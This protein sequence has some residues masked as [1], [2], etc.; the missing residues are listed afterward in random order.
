M[1]PINNF[2]DKVYVTTIEPHALRRES[3]NS[4]LKNITFEYFDEIDIT[5][6]EYRAY[7]YVGDY[8]DDFF[9]NLNLDKT[10]ARVWS[11]GQLGCFA[12]CIQLIKTAIKNDYGSVLAIEDDVVFSKKAFSV[13]EHAL[14]Q[15][16]S[17]WDLL[18]LGY[19][20]SAFHHRLFRPGKRAYYRFR[21]RDFKE[22]VPEKFSKNLDTL[23]LLFTGGFAYGL[24]KAGMK[25]VI[26]YKSPI[27][28]FGDVLFP[29]ISQ[30]S[31]FKAFLIYP[32]IASEAE[33]LSSTQRSW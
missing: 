27:Q 29:L 9:N 2:F 16:P 14:A 3:I 8:P 15:L 31:D 22:T 25:K 23:P 1:N 7:Q 17:D 30:S 20:K 13:F 21:G 18:L 28:E 12:N 32:T 4:R 33:F 26:N 19:K 5:K 10:Y 11:T 6:P 24:S